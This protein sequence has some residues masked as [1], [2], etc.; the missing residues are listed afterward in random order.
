[1]TESPDLAFVACIEAGILERQALLLFESIRAH[2]GFL[3]DAPIYAHAPRAGLGVS[4][5]T[6][7][8]LDELKVRYSE[9]V[10]NA[11]CV[12]YGS[13]NRVVAAAYVEDTT[14]HEILAVLDSDTLFL[15]EPAAFALPV[16]VD[17]ALRPVDYKGI[18]TTGVEDPY[19]S[20]WRQ[21]CAV[22]DVNYEDVPLAPSYVDRVSA[23]ASYNGGLVVA[24]R[25][26]GLLRRWADFFLASVRAGLR[27]RSQAVAFRSS[28][29]P[30]TPEASRMWGSNQAAL[31]IAIWSSTKRVQILEPTYNYPLHAHAALGDRAIEDFN[32]LVHAHYHW[33]LEKDEIDGVAL[34]SPSSN[35]DSGKLAWLRARTPI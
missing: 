21:L 23:K 27:P 24:R 10:L 25:S 12:E 1:M 15:R 22:C 34:L 6:R 14:S 18:C 5:A 30:V 11:E 29:G 9:V 32:E 16:N 2:A 8:R 28:T 20:Y 7:A 26:V 3:S 31:S 33:L 4:E 19:D 17:V 35:L 13:T